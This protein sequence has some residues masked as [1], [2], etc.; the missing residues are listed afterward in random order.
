MKATDIGNINPRQTKNFAIL[1]VAFSAIFW[2]IIVYYLNTDK[3]KNLRFE[4]SIDFEITGI[5]K[6]KGELIMNDS[7]VI[8]GMTPLIKEKSKIEKL[9]SLKKVNP[10]GYANFEMK[11]SQVTS[12]YRITKEAN[13]D[14]IVIYHYSDTLCFRLFLD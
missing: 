5:E 2:T 3:Y 12:P 9:R 6:Y 13:T 8:S 4:D 10:E 11:L 7:I 1:L 14:L